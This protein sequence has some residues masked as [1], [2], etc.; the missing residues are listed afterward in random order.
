MFNK[1]LSKN[2]NDAFHSSEN[3]QRV[4]NLAVAYLLSYQL[5]CTTATA[6]NAQK[7]LFEA[8]RD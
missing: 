4:D 6:Q 5:S 3:E 8:S 7:L 1:N 2:H